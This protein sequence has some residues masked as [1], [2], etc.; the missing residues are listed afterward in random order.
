M[1]YDLSFCVRGNGRSAAYRAV[2]SNGVFAEN[3]RKIIRRWQYGIYVE[4]SAY[5][6]GIF[7]AAYGGGY[8]TA[9]RHERERGAVAGADV[10]AACA[11]HRYD[12]ILPCCNDTLQLRFN[13]CGVGFD[14][15]KYRRFADHFK[16]KN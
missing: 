13:A 9:A 3:K 1:V 5:A 4:G 2:D 11:E 8:P 6:D 14:S 10:R 16:E 12:G 7:L 15:D